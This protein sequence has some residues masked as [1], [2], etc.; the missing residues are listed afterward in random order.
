MTSDFRE[1]IGFLNEL[2]LYDVVLPFLLVFTI[3][4]ALLEKT[5]VL[6]SDE[7]ENVKHS[8]KHL[9][10]LASFV[11]SFFVVASSRLVEI[12]TEVSANV[13]LLLLG[14]FF[15][16][17]LAGT[18]GMTRDSQSYFLENT[19]FRSLGLGI[20]FVG[21]VFIFLNAIKSG[22]KSWLEI[23]FTWLSRFSSD[24]SVSAIVLVLII[25]GF[26]Y[27]VGGGFGS[28]AP[29]TGSASADADS[30]KGG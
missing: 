1:T 6:G 9:N 29:S 23:A 3:S 11:I 18:I 14:G 30:G 5:R 22:G 8:K 26:M 25:V 19:K 20:M 12:I 4:F 15:F 17:L 13:V 27:Y 2:G 10:S 28:G 24:V 16:L 7:V 21:L